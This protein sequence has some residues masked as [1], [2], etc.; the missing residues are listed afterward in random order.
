LS[1]PTS[2]VVRRRRSWAWTSSLDGPRAELATPPPAP[3]GDPR[4]EG[5]VVAPGF[6]SMIPALDRA[7][8]PPPEGSRTTTRRLQLA[9][10]ICDPRNPLT[11]RVAVNRL[12]QH[13]LGAGLVAHA[14]Q[15]RLE[16]RPADASRAPRLARSRARGWRLEPEAP[17]PANPPL[18]HVP[19][20][21]GTS[22]GG[23]VFAAR[24]REPPS[25]A[26]QSPEARG[27]SAARRDA[28]GERH[29]QPR[30]RRS[31]FLAR[32]RCRGARGAVEKRERVGKRPRRRR[33]A[34]GAS[35]CSRSAPSSCLS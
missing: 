29:A 17:A 19:S 30:C 5:P 34:A 8:D 33:G 26:G 2:T 7:V 3:Q 10:W 15:L 9:R 18:E 27:R 25:L 32:D 14:R 23:C 6:L 11:A 12:W 22:P 16:R 35:T 28:R 20:S 21:F 4:Q 1:F 24:R 13:H 31:E